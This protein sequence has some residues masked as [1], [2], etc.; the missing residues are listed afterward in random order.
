[1]GPNLA[2]VLLPFALAT[3]A[4][5]GLRPT[6]SPIR[7][8]ELSCDGRLEPVG[9]DPF[10]VRFSWVMESEARGQAQRAYA[11]ELAT[12]REAL[13][14]GRPDTWSSGRIAGRDSVLVRYAGP[15]LAS[16]HAYFWRVRVEDAEGR[17]T[18]WSA[19]ARFVTS[20]VDAADWGEA[21]WIGYED[22][23]QRER[24]VP[25]LHGL[26][27]PARHPRLTRPVAPLLRRV[28]VVKKSV[29]QALLFV[30]GLG[31]YEAYLNG[32]KVGD[33]FLAPGWTDYEKTVLYDAFDVTA[34]LRQGP[35]AIS[36]IVGNGFHHIAPERYCKLAIAYGW[37]KLLASLRVE[38]A[39]GTRETIATGPSWKAAPSPITFTSIYGGEDFDARLEPEGW[40][41]AD[42]DDT[43]WG[44]A[45]AA[46]P[47]A[48]R[49][50][51][52][53]D[54]PLRVMETRPPVGVKPAGHG[55]F[56]YDFG[57]N[58][59]GIVHLTVRGASG[60]TVTL[61]PAELLTPDGRANQKASGE[62]CRWS[63]TLRGDGDES[64]SPR[65]TYYGFRYLQVEGA[66]PADVEAPADVPRVVSLESAHTRNAAPEVGRFETSLP[67]FGRTF[68]LVRWAIRSNL[69]S[70]LTDCPHREKLGWLEQT[71][72][73]GDAV[74]F[75]YDLLGL[76][77][78]QV[79][80][81]LDAQRADGLVPDIAPEYVAFEGGFR[82]SPEWGAAGVIVPW[83]VYRWYG[84]RDT[85]E[86]AW[87]AMTRYLDYLGAKAEG[88][89]LSHGLGDWYDLGPRFPGEAQL[90]PKAV[91]AT[92]TWFRCL[93][94]AAAAARVLGK[95][96]E[97]SGFDALAARVRAAFN[98][99]FYDPKAATWSTGSQTALAMPLVV[100]LAPQGHEPRV[101]QGLVRRIEAD[102]RALTAGDVGFHYVV[103]ALSRAGRGDLLFAMNARDDVPGYGFQLKKGATSLTESWAAL[104]EVSNNHLMLGHVMRWF[105]SG[106]LG[107]EQQER[108]VAYGS[109]VLKPQVVDGIDWARGEYRSPRGRIASAWRRER[110]RL[111]V[112]VEVPVNAEA[113][114]H[115]PAGA[116]A[117]VRESGHPLAQCRDVSVRARTGAVAV[118]ALGSGR[119]RFEVSERRMQR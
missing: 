81:V 113:E 32:A 26:V 56:V 9:V 75:N 28:F 49:L 48:G 70:V 15:P 24:L 38:Y 57:Q 61:T 45:A 95:P 73:M 3:A 59:S 65:F 91:T 68:E 84:E 85:L 111:V 72:L 86:R 80:D 67:L 58:A 109:L 110:D 53:S 12:S 94:T 119:Y 62:P 90:T 44:R 17:L 69:A 76:Y 117:E 35:N 10:R 47:P 106:L 108:S 34:Q 102:G 66:V 13:L 33:R 64:W 114:L 27:D 52:E 96:A 16:A 7:F 31:H 29:A 93:R 89:L 39:D 116:T 8:A 11:I 60:R 105:Y 5:A 2:A 6:P 100:G 55:V 46:T 77:R 112:E 97:A 1:M 25:G 42:F 92:A 107:I 51:V 22:M 40:T 37:P 41:G 88:G 74:H 50:R 99:A 4:Q 115:L 87:P 82:D 63:Y 20:L 21:R 71:Y 18:D 118:L 19:P 103:E 78:K 43:G 101:L 23:P 30:S 104:P 83:L 14:G 36:A 98:R 79:D 54:H